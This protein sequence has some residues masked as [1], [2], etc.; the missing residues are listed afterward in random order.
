MRDQK[1]AL[2]KIK[3]I[4]HSA[5]NLQTAAC[6]QTFTNTNQ[7]LAPKIFQSAD[8]VKTLSLILYVPIT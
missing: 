6:I 1:V 2:Q 8:V 5:D 3:L 4:G 7:Y